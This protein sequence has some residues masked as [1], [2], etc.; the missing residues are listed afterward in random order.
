METIDRAGHFFRASGIRPRHTD[1][2]SHFFRA[3]DTRPR[4]T[5]RYNLSY[6]TGIPERRGLDLFYLVRFPFDPVGSRLCPAQSPA[7]L[8]PCG[9]LVA[10]PFCHVAAL[11]SPFAVPP[12]PAGSLHD[13][14]G[15]LAVRLNVSNTNDLPKQA[16]R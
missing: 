11:G 5:D 16:T 1:R 7:H 8:H 12:V 10:A 9:D 15:V 13:R 4:H 2:A 3:I 14:V 6:P